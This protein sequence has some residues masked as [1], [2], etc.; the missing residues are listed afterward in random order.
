MFVLF[1]SLA[2]VMGAPRQ[3]NY[4]AANTF[5]DALAAHRRSPGLRSQALAWGLWEPQG[6]GMTA[7]RRG[8]LLRLRP[9]GVR[10][11]SLAKGWTLWMRHWGARKRGW[12]WRIW[13]WHVA[14]LRRADAGSCAVADACATW[15]SAGG[16]CERCRH[17]IA[18]S[19][20]GAARPERLG[21]LVVLVRR[22][23]PRRWDLPCGGGEG[24]P[25]PQGVGYQLVDG[26]G[27]TQ[28][29]VAR[30]ETVLPTTLVFDFPAR[31]NRQA[32]ARTGI[33]RA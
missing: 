22:W 6:T 8:R 15:A 29:T 13:I 26:C 16:E 1:W 18:P 4:A 25:A 33:C 20:V 14:A 11:L 27:S 9:A 10:A 3:A 17:G 19:V 12:W 28:S 21:A 2:G 7:P 24:R 5:L 32:V 23:L 30:A 31:S